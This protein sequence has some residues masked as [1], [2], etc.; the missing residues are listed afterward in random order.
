MYSFLYIPGAFLIPYLSFLVI[1]ALPLFFLEYAISQ[2]SSSTA[3][4]VWNICPL[5]KGSII[6]CFPG[7]LNSSQTNQ[8]PKRTLLDEIGYAIQIR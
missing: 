1:G 4:S 5:F 2:F 8:Y 6:I 7:S 3:L